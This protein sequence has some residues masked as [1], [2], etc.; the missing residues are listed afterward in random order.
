[1]LGEHEEDFH[2]I[3]AITKPQIE[4]LLKRKVLQR[5]LFDETLAEVTDSEQHVRY[6]LRRNPLRAAEVSATRESK[7]ASL[8]A[9]VR[10]ENGYLAEHPRAALAAAERRVKAKIDKLRL[11]S[12][13]SVADEERTF[14]LV[15]DET[16]LAEEAK[17][18]GCY[19]LKTDLQ[20]AEASKELVHDRYKDLAKVE[21]VFRTC[22]T[23]HLELRPVNV[24][25]E[26]R[27]RGHALVVMLAY[28]I[29]RELTQCWQKLELTVE[30]GIKELSSLCMDEVTIKQETT[31]HRIPEPRETVADLLRTADVELPP[32]LPYY[33]TRVYTRKKLTSERKTVS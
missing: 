1:L 8:Q 16:A 29:V 32:V 24:R 17:L 31:I 15:R 3:T 11:S 5:E 33:G 19:C 9:L 28:L 4:A 27:T 20:Q 14:R 7:F 26:T 6:V 23:S 13:V 12:W 10:K 25:K 18:D 30:E 2:Y 21:W 22:K